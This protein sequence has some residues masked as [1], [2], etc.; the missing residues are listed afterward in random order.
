[1]AAIET[2]AAAAPAPVEES[3]PALAPKTS[4]QEL[5]EL[6]NG[7]ETRVK[8]RTRADKETI[9]AIRTQLKRLQKEIRNSKRKRAASTQ[10]TGADGQ[11]QQ[12]AD[13]SSDPQQQQGRA[14]RKAKKAI[15]VTLKPQLAKFL[16]VSES[17]I[18]DLSVPPPPRSS[19]RPAH[20]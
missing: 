17:D 15:K 19:V 11:Q 10:T 1:M 5:E 16:G 8:E 2:A 20:A 13:A 4:M 7:M 18:M 9:L 12:P 14:P 6:I 3:V